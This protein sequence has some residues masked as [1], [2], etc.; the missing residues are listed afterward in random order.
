M[1]TVLRVKRKRCEEPLD[2]LVIER[3]ANRA[4]KRPAVASLLGDRTTSTDAERSAPRDGRTASLAALGVDV[5]EGGSDRGGAAP[6]SP[7]LAV[8]CRVETVDVADA[9]RPSTNRR[10]LR[11]IKR[12]IASGGSSS[13]R[14]HAVRHPTSSI[15]V[16]GGG[17]VSAQS[18]RARGTS[19]AAHNGRVAGARQRSMQQRRQLASR[20]AAAAGADELDEAAGEGEL[21]FF[22]V[23]FGGNPANDLTCPLIYSTFFFKYPRSSRGR[24]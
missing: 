4:N 23:T 24:G 19:R 18:E 7:R 9:G 10:V 12:R 22:T 21:S 8:M 14:W 5:D 2:S 6:E 1:V 16:S 13:Q 20:T 3:I 11:K 17:R 15:E